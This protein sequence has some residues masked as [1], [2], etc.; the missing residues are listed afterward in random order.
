VAQELTD[1]LQAKHLGSFSQRVSAFMGIDSQQGVE[2]VCLTGGQTP[3]LVN[4]RFGTP[5]WD[6]LAPP[7]PTML[8]LCHRS[9][10]T[11]TSAVR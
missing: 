8:V 10:P 7:T 1:L 3:L 11:R 2:L 6:S 4:V 9:P 5:R